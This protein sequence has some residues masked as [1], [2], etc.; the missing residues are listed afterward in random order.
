[1]LKILLVTTLCLSSGVTALSAQSFSKTEWDKI[2]L[3]ILNM[4]A[5]NNRLIE[6]GKADSSSIAKMESARDQLEKAIAECK[7]AYSYQ[8]LLTND[9]DALLAQA[10]KSIKQLTREIRKQKILKWLAMVGMAVVI[11]LAVGKMA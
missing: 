10:Q 1:M 9:K 4:V 6:D 7:L 2:S 8:I 5:E 11:I 3:G